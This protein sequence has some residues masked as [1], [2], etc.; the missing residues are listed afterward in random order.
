MRT[1][2]AFKIKQKTF[3][4]KQIFFVGGESD[5]KDA[6]ATCVESVDEIKNALGWKTCMISI[7][8]EIFRPYEHVFVALFR[9]LETNY[10]R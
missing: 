6:E 4:I 10:P 8:S 1:K 9:K 2:R 5:F 7:L 3:F